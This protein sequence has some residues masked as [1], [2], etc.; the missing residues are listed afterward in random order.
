MMEKIET[1]QDFYTRKQ[2][3]TPENIHT[4]IGHFNV[5]KLDPFCGPNAQPTPYKRRDYYKIMLT[6][7]HGRV[8]YA[9]KIIDT[10]KQALVFSNPLIPYKW[11]SVDTIRSG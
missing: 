11:D 2:I 7:G 3:P 6:L 10:E 1:I 9:D 8:Q 5:M 4:E